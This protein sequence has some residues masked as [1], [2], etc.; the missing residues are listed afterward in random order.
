[1]NYSPEIIYEDKDVL[2]INKPAGLMVHSDG[3]NNDPNL[4][5]WLLERNPEIKDVGEPIE[6]N[7]EG[8]RS[9]SEIYLGPGQPKLKHMILRPGIVHRLD[10]DTSGVMIVA[11]T[12]EAHKYLK[13]QFSERKVEKKYLALVHGNF[14]TDGGTIDKPIGRSPKDFRL[15]EA[16]S[17][18]R[19]RVREA[20][21]DFKVLERF[22]SDKHLD[23][24]SLVE[25]SPKT[26]R[27]HQIRV[28]MKSISHPI[29]CDSL[30][31]RDRR[32]PKELGLERQALH[33]ASLSIR[34]PSNPLG[35][36]MSKFEALLPGDMAEALDKLRAR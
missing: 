35:H 7:P 36:P 5:D 10:K 32:R 9:A 14:K 4:I 34:L 27:T 22:P 12:A 21:T 11:K 33:A 6:L 2:V 28:H 17:R 13:E 25:A 16:T 31:A 1:M 19:G 30:Y 26:G 29:V 3:R 20:I 24:I 8:P 15:R 23:D 18:A